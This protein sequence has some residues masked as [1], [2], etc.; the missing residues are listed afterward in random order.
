MR[1]SLTR[2]TISIEPGEEVGEEK[3]DSMREKP[4]DVESNEANSMS[5]GRGANLRV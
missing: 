2:G 1:P 5:V 4:E 3:A